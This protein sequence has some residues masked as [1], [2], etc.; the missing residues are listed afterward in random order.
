ML[1]G[2]QHGAENRGV[3]QHEHAGIGHEQFERRDAF[4][5]QSAHFLELRVAKFRDDAVK[6]VV[7]HGLA[8]GFFHPG[9]ERVA[10]GLALVLNREIDQRGRAAEGR[11]ARAGLEIVGAGGA[12][13]R[14]IQMRVHV[15]PAGNDDAALGVENFRGVVD[16]EI[17]ADR[18]DLAAGD[19]DVGR[20]RIRCGD[21]RA[22]ANDGVESHGSPSGADRSNVHLR[23]CGKD[24][25]AAACNSASRPVLPDEPAFG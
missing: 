15:D 3:V 20:V 8:V 17:L 6:G 12:A 16:G 18:D 7:G 5:D 4:A 21:D 23:L 14:H 2:L 25:Q 9:V 13:E 24:G 22:V 10:Q 19:A 1:G 11:G